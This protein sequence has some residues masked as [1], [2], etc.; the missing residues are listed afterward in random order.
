MISPPCEL[1][2]APRRAWQLGLGVLVLAILAAAATL[3]A[4]VANVDAGT[5]GK[6]AEVT[7]PPPHRV[8]AYYFFMNQRCASCRKIEAWSREAIETA[9][10]QELKDG[11]LVWRPVNVEEKGN[12]HFVK[13]YQLYTKSLILVDEHDGRQVRWA[14]LARVWELLPKKDAFLDYVRGEVRGYLSETS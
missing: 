14:N 4:P 1:A 12:E 2:R 7:A 11:Y 5:P 8:V 9:F 13:D 6:D 10:A 3:A